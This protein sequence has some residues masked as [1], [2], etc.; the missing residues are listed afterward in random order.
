M[1][2]SDVVVQ[3]DG[4]AIAVGDA[5]I[6]GDQDFAL[7]R[8]NLDGSL[9]T[10]F[11]SG[12]KVTT[13]LGGGSSD[14]AFAAV[15][16]LD[17]KVIVAGR[18]G[19]AGIG[20]AVAPARY[21]VDGTLDTSFGNNG[22]VITPAPATFAYAEAFD[23]TMQTDGNIVVGGRMGTAAFQDSYAVWR[24]NANGGLD[25]SFGSG[26]IVTTAI[27]TPSVLTGGRLDGA[28][29]VMVQ[30]DGKIVAS[31]IADNQEDYHG[32]AVVRYNANGVLDGSFGNAGVVVTN[33]L[34]QAG[35]SLDPR[36]KDAALQA[37]GKIV[38]GDTTDSASGFL[39]RLSR[40]NDSGTLDTSFGNGGT[41]LASQP[42]GPNDL[43]D[44]AI[45]A[46]GKILVGGFVL[47]NGSSGSNF[48]LLRFT[49]IA[50]RTL[51]LAMV[52]W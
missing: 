48:E 39:A 20:S 15:R 44:I 42:V 34:E 50:C 52:A 13:D 47:L 21:K 16:Q 4:K 24:Y 37:D 51:R 33:M 1:A 9:D 3:P 35:S 19:I 11:G 28:S 22:I 27:S 17:G 8:Y 23:V 31:G 10:S 46:D 43:E 25:S 7:V 6:S 29:Q 41:E 38:L 49:S 45:Q 26:G 36:R 5:A 2:A 14:F 40:L 18:R 32:V 30:Q 12:G